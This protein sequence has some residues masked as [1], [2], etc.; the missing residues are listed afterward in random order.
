VRCIPCEVV[1]Q[2]R[3]HLTCPSISKKKK[4]GGGCAFPG[5]DMQK[6]YASKCRQGKMIIDL[7]RDFFTK[8][9]YFQVMNFIPVKVSTLY[10]FSSSVS[11]RAFCATE[12]SFTSFL[13]IIECGVGIDRMSL[14]HETQ[15]SGVIHPSE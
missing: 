7:F 8:I 3:C 12:N 10:I 15:A 11:Q 5:A 4:V 14:C 1:S 6:P 2:T 9:A 13:V